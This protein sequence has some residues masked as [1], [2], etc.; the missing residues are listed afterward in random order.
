MADVTMTEAQLVA[1]MGE[2]V[3][4]TLNTLVTKFDQEADEIFLGQDI[5]DFLYVKGESLQAT[6]QAKINVLESGVTFAESEVQN[7]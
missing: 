2:A 4:N 7:G 5:A 1:A 3:L 6:F